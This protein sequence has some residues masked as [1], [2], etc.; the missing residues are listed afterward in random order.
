MFRRKHH[1]LIG[2]ILQQLNGDLL[3]E[4]HC[5]FGGGTAIALLQNE[6]RESIDIDFLVSNKEHYRELRHLLMSTT[7]IYTIAKEG[8]KLLLARDIRADQ[9]G[10][11]TMLQSADVAIK[12]EI[13]LEGRIEFDTPDPIDSI[14]GITTLTRLDLL[15]SKLLA[16]SDRWNDQAVFSRDIIDLV[17]LDPGKEELNKAL[18]KAYSAYGDSIHK[19]LHKALE[20]LLVNNDKL[21]K[22][23]NWLKIDT[24]K[25]LLWQKLYDLKS[26]HMAILNRKM[27]QKIYQAGKSQVK[28]FIEQDLKDIDHILN[29]LKDK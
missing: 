10:I 12:F 5:Y 15:T 25:A 27:D 1:Q 19:D 4:H 23:I 20:A 29:Y 16:N 24:P 18:L 3:R 9:Y 8:S 17:M 22:C 21:E 6:Y 7:G 13:V 11:R 14:E 26:A 28:N 2:S